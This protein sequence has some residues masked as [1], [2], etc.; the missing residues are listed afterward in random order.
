MNERYKILQLVQNGKI[1]I[2]Q[3]E[4]LID[5]L[6]LPPTKNTHRF[7]IPPIDKPRWDRTA[8]ELKTLGTQVSTMVTQALVDAKREIESQV[9]EWMSHDTLSQSYDF[10]LL[11]DVAHVHVEIANG[12]IRATEWDKPYGR[13]S[14]Y[15][16]IRATDPAEAEKTL[17]EAVHTETSDGQYRLVIP[18]NGNHGMRISYVDIFVPSTVETLHLKSRNG[19]L[20]VD[21]LTAHELELEAQNGDITT[22]YIGAN[23]VRITTSNGRID[24]FHSIRSE[25][26][27]VYA[28]T[29]NGT[30]TINGIETNTNCTGTARTSLGEIDIDETHFDVTY[31]DPWRKKKAS[32]KN[33]ENS[34]NS[35]ATSIH[36]ETS[37]GRITIKPL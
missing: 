37:N 24:L 1:T 12:K 36:C 5:A 14:I 19:K 17:L 25:T 34:E 31:A 9:G 4:M 35:I 28:A 21:S 32:F 22:S 7:R 13:I 15:A 23:L 18:T 2:E 11:E 8:K 20:K 30:I 16:Q 10:E 33:K 6:N 29:K 3:A 27:N 26:K